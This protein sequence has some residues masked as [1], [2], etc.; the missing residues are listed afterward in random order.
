[1]ALALNQNND[2]AISPPIH[3][4]YLRL[5]GIVLPMFLFLRDSTQKEGFLVTILKKGSVFTQILFFDFYPLEAKVLG[6]Y[7]ITTAVGCG[8]CGWSCYMQQQ[9]L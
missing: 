3:G 1:M 7:T 2:S 5:G 4:F 8:S 6:Y 9:L